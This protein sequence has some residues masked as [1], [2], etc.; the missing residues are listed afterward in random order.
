[1]LWPPG[2]RPCPLPPNLLLHLR[3]RTPR[4]HALRLRRQ[5][6]IPT[7]MR[8]LANQLSLAT[9]PLGQQRGRGRTAQDTRMNEARKA[10]AGDVARGAE[11]ALE[12]PDGF[13]RLRVELVEEAAAVGGSEDA[14]EAPRLVLQ[15]LHVLD[16]DEEDVAGLGGLDLKGPGQVVDAGEVDVF[17]VVGAVVVADLAAGPVDA[18]DFDDFVVFD[19]AG[20]GDCNGM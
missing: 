12:V 9:I 7:Q 3:A 15:W 18:F 11:D 4:M 2:H 14:G 13:S 17:D 16:L 6:H 19:G 8:T 5:R 20:E 1:M 10:H